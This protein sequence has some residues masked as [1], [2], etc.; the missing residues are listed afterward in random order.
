MNAKNKIETAPYAWPLPVKRAFRKLGEDLRNARRRRRIPTSL[1]AQRASISRTTLYKVE[2]GEPG[3]SFGIYA[4]IIFSLGFI[5]RLENLADFRN[6]LLGHELEEEYLPKRVRGP[7]K[8][9][10]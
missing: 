5:D 3:V 7:R 10:P 6:D 1:L 9:K 2:N 4:S 8:E